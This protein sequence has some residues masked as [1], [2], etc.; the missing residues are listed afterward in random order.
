MSKLYFRHGAMNSGKSTALLQAALLEPR[1]C[2]GGQS[3][4]VIRCNP[5]QAFVLLPARVARAVAHP[6]QQRSE[7]GLVR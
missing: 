6:L 2:C 5:L 1:A 3:R 7:R 4:S